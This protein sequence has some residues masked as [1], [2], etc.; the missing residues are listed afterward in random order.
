MRP[1]L[2]QRLDANSR[3]AAQVFDLFEKSPGAFVENALRDLRTDAGQLLQLSLRGAVDV[4]RRG[5]QRYF[6]ITLASRSARTGRLLRGGK[7]NFALFHEINV[8]FAD[9]HPVAQ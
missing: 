8:L 2:V 3:H 9:E 1:Q 5:Q 7:S 6:R 4:N